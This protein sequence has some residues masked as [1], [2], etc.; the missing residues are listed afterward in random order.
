MNAK[1]CPR[2]KLGNAVKAL[3]SSLGTTAYID[4]PFAIIHACTT[5]TRRMFSKQNRK[6]IPPHRNP[7]HANLTTKTGSLGR[8]QRDTDRAPTRLKRDFLEGTLERVA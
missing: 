2:I 8:A 1:A 7:S 6:G 4:T 5:D 3:A